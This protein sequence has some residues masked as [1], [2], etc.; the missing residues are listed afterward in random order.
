[1]QFA[2]FL[3]VLIICNCSHVTYHVVINC[4]HNMKI[5]E[6][7]KLRFS[8][9]GSRGMNVCVHLFCVRAVLCVGSG[10]VTG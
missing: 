2:L 4:R 6:I 7:I 1:M 10:V 9:L 8:G 5:N 3:C